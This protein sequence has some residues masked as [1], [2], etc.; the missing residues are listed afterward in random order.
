M[1]SYIQV[2]L[3][4]AQKEGN[5]FETNALARADVQ[6]KKMTTMIEDFLSLARLEEGKISLNKS[7]FSLHPLI[8]ETAND[9]KFLTSNHNIEL[10]DCEEIMLYAD[11]DKIGQ[12][13]MNLLSNAIKYSPR[14]GDIIIGCE[15]LPGKVKIY[16]S[17]EGVG[18]SSEDQK[19]LFERFYRS[20]NEKVKTISGFGIGLYLVSEILKYHNSKIE[21]DSTEGKGSTFYFFLDVIS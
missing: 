19:R 5:S 6:A 18:I 10:H 20:R 12:V 21:V 16:V 4:K 14:G 15:K 9:A 7:E 8:E 2:L 13:V 1:K 11:R 17:D 3:A